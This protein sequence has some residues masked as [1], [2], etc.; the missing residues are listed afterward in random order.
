MT[1][2]GSADS[3]FAAVVSMSCLVVPSWRHG[4]PAADATMA[5]ESSATE[6]SGE[7]GRARAESEG[8]TV[9]TVGPRGADGTQH[10]EFDQPSRNP[11]QNSA[12]GGGYER[13]SDTILLGKRERN[14]LSV[15][16]GRMLLSRPQCT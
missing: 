6:V 4:G 9:A 5:D 14:A 11:R 8:P 2:T 15:E 12:M 7:E 16:L 3:S 13:V 1:G 10:L